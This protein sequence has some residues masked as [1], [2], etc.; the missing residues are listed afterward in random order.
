METCDDCG[1]EFCDKILLSEHRQKEH[2]VENIRTKEILT[3]SSSPPRKK[4]DVPLIWDDDVDKMEVDMIDME[5]EASNVVQIMLENRIR[6][7][8]A[9]I[10]EMNQQKKEDKTNYSKLQKDIENLKCNNMIP[11]KQKIPKHLFSVQEKHLPFL[12]GYRMRFMSDPNGACLEN[13][14]SVHLY[15]DPDEGAKLKKRVNNHVAD[16]W[17]QYYHEKIPLPYVETVGVG[18]HAKV[19]KKKT[20]EEMIDFLRGEESLMVYSNYQELLAIANMFNINI[21]IFTFSGADHR[22]SQV[23]PDPEFVSDADAKF[24]KWAPDMALYHSDNTHYDLLVKDDS[25]LALLGLLAGLKDSKGIEE[26]IK[27]I[28]EGG[29]KDDNRVHKAKSGEW[30][31]VAFKAKKKSEDV[32]DEVLLEDNEESADTDDLVEETTLLQN[33]NSGHRRTAPQQEFENVSKS[34]ALYQCDKCNSELE[35]Q[36]LLTAHVASQ[37]GPKS[38]LNCEVCD[39]EFLYERDL[40]SHMKTQHDDEKEDD[41]APTAQ[42]NCDDCSFQGG[43]ASELIN[44]LKI[45]GHQPSRAKQDNRKIFKDF[46][47]CYT[48]EMEFDGYYNLME[49]RKITHPSNKRCKNFPGSCT[50]GNKC[51][52]LH[53]EPMDTEPSMNNEENIS[54]FNCNMCDFTCKEKTIFMMH[55]KSSHKEV[56]KLCDKFQNGQCSRSEADC[57]FNHLARTSPSTQNEAKKEQVFQKASSDPFPPDHMSRMFWMVSNLC[58]KVEN[59]EKRFEELM[60]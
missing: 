21:D 57:W 7:L 4:S 42:W 56:N 39:D 8:E 23:N 17:Y 34:K 35:S 32:T 52:Y 15:E 16:H 18:E 5:M 45:T 37:H 44:H 27:G 50:F 60:I 38:K 46:K 28:N 41:V 26:N 58:R 1:N 6:E 12:R 9:Q 14:A 53:I 24:G 40:N 49:H 55:K 33:K 19:V 29:I 2:L 3:P 51:W 59:M 22:W 30:K 43:G 10:E 11:R 20:A 25:R 36:G 31:K 54:N 47:Q 13:S 48:C